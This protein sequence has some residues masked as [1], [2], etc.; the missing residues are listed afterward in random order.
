MQC[1]ASRK[2]IDNKKHKIVFYALCALYVLSVALI[3][4]ETA[5]FAIGVFVSNA[6][7][8]FNVALISCAHSPIMS[9]YSSTW[10]L[11]RLYYSVAVTFLR[12]VSLYVQL[13]IIIYSIYS[14][15]L[16]RYTVAGSCGVAT[17]VW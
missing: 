14:S 15:N 13:T 5:F 16:Q 3:S 7:F 6:A 9:V 12:N 8:F 11:L 4:V 2:E 17:S 10:K 1:H